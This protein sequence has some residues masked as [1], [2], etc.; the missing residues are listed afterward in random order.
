MRDI[1]T[2][3]RRDF[4]KEVRVK[5][6]RRQFGYVDELKVDFLRDESDL[7][8][9]QSVCNCRWVFE[10]TGRRRGDRGDAVDCSQGSHS[11]QR[12]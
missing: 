8:D 3:T 2:T 7:S 9:D 4:G 12:R 5:Q 10:M 6:R 11:P 1:A